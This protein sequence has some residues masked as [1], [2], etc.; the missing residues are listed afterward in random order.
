VVLAS[1]TTQTEA[2]GLL[3]RFDQLD[4]GAGVEFDVII[5]IVL[6]GTAIGGGIGTMWRTFIGVW[7]LD[8]YEAGACR[9]RWCSSLP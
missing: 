1:A 6:G 9:K 2:A 7:F 4:A 8:L 3:G 5:A